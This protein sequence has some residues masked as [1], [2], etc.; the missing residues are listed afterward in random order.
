MVVCPK[1]SQRVGYPCTLK[2]TLSVFDNYN[3]AAGKRYLQ[4]HFL[5]KSKYVS[6]V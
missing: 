6:S 3:I 5:P 4:L 2:T 1:L